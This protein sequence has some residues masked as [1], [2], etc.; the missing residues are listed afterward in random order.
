MEVQEPQVPAGVQGQ[1]PCAATLDQ[2][3]PDERFRYAL[4]QRQAVLAAGE[5]V[6]VVLGVGHHAEDA[7]FG[8]G[9]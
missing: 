3:G 4:E 2:S 6:R 1:S 9:V 8:D 7:E 5:G